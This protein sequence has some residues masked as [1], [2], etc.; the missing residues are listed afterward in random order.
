MDK[1]KI[2]K[3]R[4]FSMRNLDVSQEKIKDVEDEIERLEHERENENRIKS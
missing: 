4:L 1:I 2:L 3:K